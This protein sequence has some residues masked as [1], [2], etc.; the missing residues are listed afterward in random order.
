MKDKAI[1]V[2]ALELKPG[3]EELLVPELIP[4]I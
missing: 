4:L 2:I 3:L 1:H